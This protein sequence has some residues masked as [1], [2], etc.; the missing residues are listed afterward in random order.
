[1]GVIGKKGAGFKVFREQYGADVKVKTEA[2]FNDLG[3][4]VCIIGN[5]EAQD[6][7]AAAIVNIA[8]EQDLEGK[9]V[10]GVIVPPPVAGAVIGKA[11]SSLTAVR[12]ATGSFVKMARE[13]IGGMRVATISGP[14]AESV[15]KAVAMVADQ[16]RQSKEMR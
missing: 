3:R 14:D 9:F 4:L 1:M 2:A 10:V 6:Q 16:M 7:A 13:P 15:G 12:S 8:S 11:G 5:A